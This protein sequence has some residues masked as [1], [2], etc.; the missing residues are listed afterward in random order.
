[1][2]KLLATLPLLALLSCTG[3]PP[4]HALSH[5]D[6]TEPADPQGEK[7]ETWN[8]VEKPIVTFGSTDVRYPRA[9][10]CAAA[11]TDQ[12]T[13]TGWRGEKVSA[14][15]VISAPAAV[16]GLTCTVG[17]FVADN[18]AKLPGIACARFVKY[19]VSDRF[20]TDQPCGARPENNPAHLEA[21]LLDEAASCDVPARSTRP[22]WITVDIPRDATPGRYTAPVAVKGEGVAE[23][24]TLH[25]NVT[26]RTL[27]APSEWTLPPRLV[28][29]SGGRGPRRKGSR[30]VERRALRTPCGRLV[31]HARRRR[32]EGRHG[33]AQQGPLEPPVLRRLRRH[34]PSGR[35][36]R[37]RHVGVRLSRSSTAGCG[38]MRRPGR[39]Q[40]R[41]TA[42]RCCRGTTMLHYYGCRDGRIRRR[43][44]R[45][46][47]ARLPTRCGDRSCPHF[48]AS[49]RREKGW[50][51]I[52][53][54]A[55]DERSPEVMAAATAL[56]KE[57]APELGIALADNHNIFKQYPYIKDMCAS[58][59]GPSRTDGHRPA[60]QQ[61]ADDH[62]LRLLFVGIPEHLH[63]R[64][65]RPR[66]PI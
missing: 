38:F 33:D 44:G 36:L 21:D 26:E 17:D 25:L 47:H 59:F 7:P 34:D 48:V 30:P 5:F 13:L 45:S 42:I 3:I 51:G 14:Q 41:S 16:G 53:N 61:G 62:L 20:L 50:L 46:G 43:P 58:I 8:G 10:P 28:A 49:P 60:P 54:I 63:L 66:R 1:M 56:L 27:P 2:K 19:V 37:R 32:A 39:R 22:V 12:T 24:L 15:A 11:V 4:Q 40:A 9:T 55:M 18:G 65:R 52:T 31:R 64:R 23:T 29:A 57:V 6:W 35:S